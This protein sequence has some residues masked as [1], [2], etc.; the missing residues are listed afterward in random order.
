M[1]KT[2]RHC[3]Y[4]M[5]IGKL[6]ELKK[7]DQFVLNLKNQIS[8]FIFNH[9]EKYI[10]LDV[11]TFSQYYK[12][13]INADS[14][15]SAWETQ[16]LFQDICA[17]YDVYIKMRLKGFKFHIQKDIRYSYYKRKINNH[18]IGDLKSKEIL[19]RAPKGNI[20]KIVK[21][22]LFV[23][24]SVKIP[25]KIQA[26]LDAYPQSIQDR[27]LSLAKSIRE[28]LLKKSHVIVFTTGSYRKFGYMTSSKKAQVFQIN[29]AN[30][31]YKHWYCYRTRMGDHW[32]PLQI[33][34]NYHRTRF[35]DKIHVV[36]IRKNKLEIFLPDEFDEPIFINS[37]RM[38][39][40]VDLNIKHNF[41]TLSN[42]K[43][44]DYNR[45]Y[46]KTLTKL[47]KKCD[48]IK[49]NN[50]YSTRKVNA[51]QKRVSRSLRTNEW[52][53]KKLVSEILKY[54][55]ENHITDLVLEDL[56]L[57]NATFIKSDDFEGIKYSRLAKILRLSNVKN[58]MLQQAEK[59]GIRI[60]TTP[61]IYTS[62][63]CPVCGYID[64][65]NRKDQ[66]HF[67]CVNCSYSNNADLNASFNIL[68]RYSSDVL[69]NSKL[70]HSFDSFQRM[71]ANSCNRKKLRVQEFLQ[72]SVH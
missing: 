46:L 18:N 7:V 2:I 62:Q 32:L 68:R 25:E 43:I 69:R 45:T 39:V 49:L 27:I 36:T 16:A 22:L 61:S 35:S 8:E 70:L 12:Q 71:M 53:F 57:S 11:Y 15:L 34:K 59:N 33:N 67:K 29:D 9:L 44:F 64:R 52:Y 38:I 66:E 17:F 13:F 42:G 51:A 20:A 65:E 31:L 6:D 30:H 10:A 23:V 1:I 14:P 37:N 21:Y 50:N 63:Q 47:L 40:G 4:F 28:R 48:Q 60:H 5:N 54:C 24:D 3:S 55:V 72:E 41:A 56:N 19:F 26:A 58:W